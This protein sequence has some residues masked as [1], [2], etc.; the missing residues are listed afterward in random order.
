MEAEPPYLEWD[1]DGTMLSDHALFPDEDVMEQLDNFEISKMVAKQD[2]MAIIMG[3][4]EKDQ[5]MLKALLGNANPNL[6]RPMIDAQV[7]M[8]RLKDIMR[9]SVGNTASLN[10]STNNRVPGQFHP[11]GKCLH[12]AIIPTNTN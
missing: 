10:E 6:V 1:D 8:N 2:H 5:E 12:G 7:Q 3:R 4:I 11:I 9:N